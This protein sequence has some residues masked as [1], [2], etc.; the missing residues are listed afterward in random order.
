MVAPP[1]AA[2]WSRHPGEP[3]FAELAGRLRA[4]SPQARAWWSRHE[5]APL[6][7]GTKLLRHAALGEFELRHVVLQVADDPGQKLVTFAAADR[8]QMRIAALV[9][10]IF[11]AN[12][13]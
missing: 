10:D 2:A 11:P 4:A 3:G 5:V 1:P 9:A 12:E 8:D 6:S 13:S 7:S